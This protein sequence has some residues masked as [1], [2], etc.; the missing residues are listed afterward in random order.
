MGIP[1]SFDF[2]VFSTRYP[3]L[4][5]VGSSAAQ[6]YFNE[7][8]L[9]QDNTG[10]CTGPQDAATQLLLLNMLT[11]HI[12]AMNNANSSPLV[13]RIS[14]A[15]EGSVSVGT[16]F[17]VPAGSPQWFAQ[18]KYG[19]AWWNA[20]KQYRTMRYVPRRVAIGFR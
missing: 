7:A 9:Y 14:N 12:A 4:A 16:S 3:E 11:A 20:T 17:E 2:T 10:S 8:C 6:L 18:T 15:T 19:A 13:G 1:V 5:F